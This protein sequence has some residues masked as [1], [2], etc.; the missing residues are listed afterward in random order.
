MRL[1]EV[2]CR[3]CCHS[4]PALDGDS[5]WVCEK[6]QMDIPREHAEH[7]CRSHVYIPALVPWE[8]T[9]ANGP[10]NWIEYRLPT[11]ELVRN[12]SRETG[13]HEST[14]LHAA[15]RAGDVRVLLEGF[16]QEIREQLGGTVGCR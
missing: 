11:G 6:Y 7:G 10:D 1:P 14:E 16:V 2:T 3:S 4:T 8:Q 13:A 12:G 9:N 5:R 15:Q